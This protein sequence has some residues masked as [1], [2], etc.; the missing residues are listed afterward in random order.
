MRWSVKI[1]KDRHFRW[2]EFTHILIWFVL[3]FLML[4]GCRTVLNRNNQQPEAKE[5]QI[6]NLKHV[7]GEQCIAF[8]SKVGIS[9]TS[10]VPDTNAV[11]VTGSPEQLC[12]AG[13]VLDLV[14]TKEK[15]IIENLGSASSVRTLPSNSQIATV[16]DNIRIGTF[17]N[18]PRMDEHS[19][20]L[21][22]IQGNSVV[23]ILPAHH[24]E[25]LLKLLT[26]QLY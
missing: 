7:S 4:A 15:F 1:I 19:R 5:Q 14:D 9:E 26:L 23:A 12:R 2:H 13:L 20:G 6:F 16:L 24:R 10:L 17:T 11:S 22:D 21:I 3:I 8:L 25:Q 18:P